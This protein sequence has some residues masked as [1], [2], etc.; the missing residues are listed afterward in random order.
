MDDG[1]ETALSDNNKQLQNVIENYK[2]KYKEREKR[3]AIL[4]KYRIISQNRS[5][6]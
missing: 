1:K 4:Q 3:K 2:G 5:F 6:D